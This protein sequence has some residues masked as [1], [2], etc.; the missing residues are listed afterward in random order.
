VHRI[1][2]AFIDHLAESVDLDDLHKAMADASAALD[3]SCFAYLSMPHRRGDEAQVVSTSQWVG[4]VLILNPT[5]V[6]FRPESYR[7]Q[8]D[9]SYG[10]S[11]CFVK[12]DAESFGK[13]RHA[14]GLG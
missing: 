4:G 7:N 11:L 5:S 8:L 3:L 6:D 12:I 2:Q 10:V 13:F 14:C 1:F 9:A